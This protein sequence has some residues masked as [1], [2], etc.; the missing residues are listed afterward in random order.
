ME[1]QLI[2]CECHNP[3][4]QMIFEY[5]NDLNCVYVE[6]H[7]SPMPFFKR[8]LHGIKYIFGYRSKF[9]DFDEIIVGNKYGEYFAELG[10]KL[11]QGR[12]K[13]GTE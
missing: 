10:N 2:I 7:L 3:E 9:G 8:L 11:V 1:E 5:D 12:K 6:Y 13:E 4:H